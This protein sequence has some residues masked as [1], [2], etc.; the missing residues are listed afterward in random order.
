VF[1]IQSLSPFTPLIRWEDG[2]GL[3]FEEVDGGGRDGCGIPFL[4]TFSVP[5]PRR[6]LVGLAGRL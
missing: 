2:E 3:F 6:R 4:S 1:H 5:P